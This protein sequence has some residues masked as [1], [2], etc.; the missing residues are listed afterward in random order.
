MHN[1]V[2]MLQ[3]AVDELYYGSSVLALVCED[4]EKEVGQNVTC[5]WD[6][7]AKELGVPAISAMRR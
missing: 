5:L 3:K 7:V 1:A 4:G 2:R 6:I